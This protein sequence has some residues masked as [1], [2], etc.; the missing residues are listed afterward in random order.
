[1]KQLERLLF[2]QGGRCFFCREPIPKGEASVEHLLAA[3]NGGS[4]EDANCVVCCKTLNAA[5]GNLSVKA[6]FDAILN[7][8]GE[9]HCPRSGLS[10]QASTKPSDE[11]PATEDPQ[12]PTGDSEV[13][14]SS[15]ETKRSV[16]ESRVEI[17]LERLKRQNSSRPQRISTLT[18]AIRS[19]FQKSLTPALPAKSSLNY[20][21]DRQK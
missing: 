15:A 18:N 20:G 19:Y 12:E 16:I 3:S 21:D 6:K 14:A 5:L 17:V 11:E 2:L 7:Q 1:M 9:F 13:E 4:R 10:P 8:N